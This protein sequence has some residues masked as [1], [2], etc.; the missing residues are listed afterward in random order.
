MYRNKYNNKKVYVDG[1]KFDSRG[2]ARRYSELKLLERANE[3]WNLE[4][5]PKFEL[6]PTFKKKGITHRSI[7]YIA[8]FK[9][10]DKQGN[11]VVEDFKGVETEVFKIKR[12]LFEYKYPELTLNI[13]K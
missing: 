1:I 9:Y 7:N 6:L 12:K 3:I 8:D 11:I 13:V 10:T 2:E 4:L 5:Q